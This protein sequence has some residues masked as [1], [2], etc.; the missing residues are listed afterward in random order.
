[1]SGFNPPADLRSD[2]A[3][4]QKICKPFAPVCT[5]AIILFLRRL[6]L[7]GYSLTFA[8]T[9]T[10]VGTGTLT[11]NR[12]TFSMTQTTIA[13]DIQQAFDAHLNF[14]TQLTFD[15]EFVGDDVTDGIQLIVDEQKKAGKISPS[16][17]V[18]DVLRLDALGQAQR[19][20]GEG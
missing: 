4:T 1:M 18:E 20:L 6:L 11:T 16:F 3:L 14:R 19:D 15:F 5:G 17:N 12:Q 2:P 9:C 8:F 7:T 10:A 13:G